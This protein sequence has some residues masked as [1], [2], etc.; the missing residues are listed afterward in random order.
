MSAY[1]KTTYTSLFCRVEFGRHRRVLCVPLV[2]SRLGGRILFVSCCCFV[3]RLPTCILVSHV[4]DLDS[5][6]SYL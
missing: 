6:C 2:W 3:V 4:F 5:P 1:C